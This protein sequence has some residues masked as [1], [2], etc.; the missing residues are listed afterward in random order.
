VWWLFYASAL[1][2]LQLLRAQ[3]QWMA[4]TDISAGVQGWF[5]DWSIGLVIAVVLSGSSIDA[6]ELANSNLFQHDL[7]SMGLSTRHLK[8]LQDKRCF[9]SVIFENA[10]QL[11]AQILFL[12]LLGALDEATFIALLPSSVS[13]VLSRM[14]SFRI[15]RRRAHS[16]HYLCDVL[17][18]TQR[19]S[20]RNSRLR[21]RASAHFGRRGRGRGN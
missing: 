10:P 12:S 21:H 6:I 8:A 17:W 16:A 4:A 18:F 15:P 11:A 2:L 20:N 19:C 14:V 9:S 5:I 1:N 13:I 7:F 3:K